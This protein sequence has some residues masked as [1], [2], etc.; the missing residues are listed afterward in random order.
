MLGSLL[1]TNTAGKTFIRLDMFDGPIELLFYLI[2]KNEIDIFDVPIAQLTDDYLAF[3]RSA[4]GIDLAFVSDFLVMAAALLRLKVRALL[5]RPK[6]E[7]LTTPQVSLEQILEAY[8]QFQEAAR[9][10]GEREKESLSRFPRRGEIPRAQ[11]PEGEEV[12]LLT[13]AFSRLLGRLTPPS[14]KLAPQEVKLEDK[15]TQLRSLLAT[16]ETLDFEEAVSEWGMRTIAELIVL[17]LALL[18]L[19]RLGEVRVEQ[20]GEFGPIR[21]CRKLDRTELPSNINL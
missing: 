3:L 6:E 13:R 19:V 17:F 15:I 1:H 12:L 11:W 16:R 20:T 2:R 5:P 9:A 10:L 8:R 7:D 4:N 18:E 21:L 14:V